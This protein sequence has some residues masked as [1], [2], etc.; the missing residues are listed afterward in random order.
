MSIELDLVGREIRHYRII[1][2]LGEGGMGAV[3]AAHDP[4]LDRRVALKILPPDL[5]ASRDRLTR[6]IQEA[7]TASALSHPNVITIHDI[8]HHRVE[9]EGESHDLHFISMELIEGKTLRAMIRSGELELKRG[10]K[11]IAEVADGLSV[12]HDAGIIH[13]DVKPENVMIGPAGNAKVLDFGLAKLRG[14]AGEAASGQSDTAVMKTDHGAVLGTVGYMSPEQAQG[15]PIDHRSD[16]FAL[17][18]I[19]Y[20]VTT[21]RRAFSGDSTVDTLHKIIHDK[22]ADLREIA[23]DLPLQLQW[24]LRKA[25]AKDPDERYQSV[26]DLAIDIRDLI[27]ELDSN[28]ELTTLSG[29]TRIAASRPAR[30]T[31]IALVMVTII[32]LVAVGLLVWQQI[33]EG[34]ASATS[35]AG[36]ART[37]RSITSTG[38]VIS[39][40]ISPDGKYV[41][42]VESWQGGQSLWVR[43]MATS[44]TLEL[45]PTDSVA[46][47][48]LAFTNDSSSII[49]GLK[50]DRA[51]DGALFQIPLIGGMPR[52][53]VDGIDSQ[54][55][56]SPDGTRMAWLRARYP[57]KDQSA[58]M[59]ANVDGS[60]ERI[61]ATRRHPEIFAPIFFVAPSWSHDG[62]S[63]ATAVR[64]E[65]RSA[66][67]IVV[68]DPETG[69][70]TGERDD[71]WS[72]VAAVKW[73]P[74]DDGILAIAAEAPELPAQVW[75]LP[76]PDGEP[77]R[78]T[79]DLNDHRM[80]T[81]TDDGASLVTVASDAT[82]DIFTLAQP[83]DPGVR[84]SSAILDGYYGTSY[85]DDGRIVYSG[86]ENGRLDIWL[87]NGDGSER[88]QLTNDPEDDR[89]PRFAKDGIVYVS[90]RSSGLEI[91]FVDF[92]GG[93]SRAVA[94]TTERDAPSVTPDGAWVI[95]STSTGGDS[96][97]W[98][99]ATSGGTPVQLT[100]MTSFLPSV[101]PD[102]S[103]IAF[104]Y[105]DHETK[106]FRIG[107]IPI[108][109]GE[110]IRSLES[111]VPHEA[112]KIVWTPDE[113]GFVLNT[114]ERDRANLWLQPLEGG[115]PTQLTRFDDLRIRDFDFA[116]DGTTLLVSRGRLTRDAVLI[117]DFR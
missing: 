85:T 102:G 56:F 12:A 93:R 45:V 89:Y 72:W 53:L 99:V 29:S 83:T 17:G 18:C 65:D 36:S 111:S 7:R 55:T 37:M 91:R 74:D 11:I 1:S 4:N 116:P 3:Y 90:W 80:V 41:A 34:R 2:L 70:Q 114:A 52:H 87:M 67:K 63:I 10:L 5:V 58:V 25:L 21:G 86:L 16:V 117:T 108:E 100:E 23:P 31:S 104:Y 95:Y 113:S 73:L 43:Q 26:K 39:A 47:W 33:D 78:V 15:K 101:S 110:I 32:A 112:S 77:R 98:K 62:T 68:I 69:Q 71:G 27:R 54:P 9:I 97:I 96:A 66:A 115:P 75:L 88:V 14:S 79:N 107:V 30:R 50:A 28:P 61:L 13:R 48:G 82:S 94:R 103:Q 109:G 35:A 81:L 105:V 84:V 51:I 40:A 19:L 64:D 42:F 60:D 106:Q 57:T 38:K 24:I 49:Y 76:W 22:P 59:V 46:Y 8:G 20:E 6:F 44:Q 92:D